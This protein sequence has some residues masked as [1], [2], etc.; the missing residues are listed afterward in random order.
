MQKAKIMVNG[1]PGKMAEQVAGRILESNNLELIPYSLTGPEIT[2]DNYLICKLIKPSEREEKIK[3]IISK[4]GGFISVD[5]THPDAVNDNASFYCRKNLPFVMGTTGGNRDLLE[6]RVKDSDIAAVIA[7]N[8]AKQIVAFQSLINKFSLIWERKWVKDKESGLYIRE[9]HQGVDLTEDFKGKADTSGT[10]KA[11]V[12]YFN[13]L[14][15]DYE[16]HE[17]N[18]IRDMED[19]LKL[20][21]PEEHLKGHGWHMYKLFS[22]EKNINLI[23]SLNMHIVNFLMKSSV[24]SGYEGSEDLSD[25]R[26]SGVA[27]KSSDGNVLFRVE[28]RRGAEVKIEHNVNGRGIYAEGTIDGINFL[29]EKLAKKKKG[30]VYSMMDVLG[31]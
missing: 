31:K 23:K 30:K 10:A 4:E 29:G 6:Q 8:M 15:I 2:R 12:G 22:P 28:Y 17:I 24:F 14:G 18:K 26:M 21:V 20:G 9:S 13:R 5:Y 25:F 7:P 11:M 1:L 3:E 16:V 27:I 19:Q